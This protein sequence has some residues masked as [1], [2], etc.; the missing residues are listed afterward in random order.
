MSQFC[1][2]YVKGHWASKHSLDLFTEGLKLERV[3]II[4]Y[5]TGKLYE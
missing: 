1:S 2:L 4:N 5:D 3:F